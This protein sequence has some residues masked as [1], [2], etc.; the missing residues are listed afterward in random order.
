MRSA[1]LSRSGPFHL[2]RFARGLEGRIPENNYTFQAAMVLAA[3]ERVGPYTDRVASFLGYPR[4]FVQV[5][6][7]R[8]T[9]A[10]IWDG[11]QVRCLS[12]RRAHK[13]AQTLSTPAKPPVDE[14][15]AANDE[16][17]QSNQHGYVSYETIMGRLSHQPAA[18]P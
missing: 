2:R 5:I 16:A 10:R 15:D 9:E 1:L 3:S 11:D 8:L 18:D 13:K 14:P 4:G 6:S 17:K 12:R 7:G